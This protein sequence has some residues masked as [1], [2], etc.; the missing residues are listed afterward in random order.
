MK[1]AGGTLMWC[2]KHYKETVEKKYKERGFTLGH[3]EPYTD[4]VSDLK[5]QPGWKFSDGIN[6][7]NQ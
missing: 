4:L 5:M 6:R 7:R 3:H 2:D 1:N